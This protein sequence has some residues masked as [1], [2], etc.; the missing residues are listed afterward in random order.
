MIVGARGRPAGRDGPDPRGRRRSRRRGA[1][2]RDARRR[3]R[4]RD[5]LGRGEGATARAR[6]APSSS[7]TT[8]KEDVAQGGPRAT[9]A[10]RGV[11]VVVDTVGEKTWMTSLQLGRQGRPHRHLRRHVGA[12]PEG[13]DPPDLLEAALDP[14]LHDGERPRVPG[15][16][17][18]V[19]AGKLK[20][21]IDRIFPLSQAR[22]AYAYMEEGR[23]HGKIVLVPDGSRRSGRTG[24]RVSLP[25]KCPGPPGSLRGSPRR[26]TMTESSPR[27]AFRIHDLPC[28]ERPASGSCA[29]G[30]EP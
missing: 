15:A 20:P 8:R 18:A 12:Q 17:D 10:K 24:I 16:L 6:P 7:S 30:P 14:R 28:E 4:A 1:R 27:R 13:G 5:D 2:D 3:A 26:H 22:A 29:W 19:A 21:R 25:G 23:Q 9:P 11:D